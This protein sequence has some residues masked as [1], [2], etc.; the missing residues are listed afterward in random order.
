[1]SRM[2]INFA[3]PECLI[4]FL[5]IRIYNKKMKNRNGVEGRFAARYPIEAEVVLICN[6]EVFQ[7]H[8][9]NFS[10]LGILLKKNLPSTWQG[11]PIYIEVTYVTT[12]KKIINVSGQGQ[13]VVGSRRRISITQNAKEFQNFLDVITG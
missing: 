3:Y 12:K 5:P 10:S 9:V 11:Q 6:Q 4:S 13:L 7:T 1:M 8:S 2:K